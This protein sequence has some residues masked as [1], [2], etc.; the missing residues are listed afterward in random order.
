MSTRPPGRGVTTAERLSSL[1]SVLA[2]QGFARIVEAHSGLSAIIGETAQAIVNGQAVGYDAIWASGFTHSASKG[3]PDASIVGSESLLHTIDE[4][5]SVTSKPLMVDGDTGGDAVQLAYLVR[6]LER[7][8][9]SAVVI[10]D[11]VFPK[12]NS[13]DPLAMQTM[14]SPE[15][16]AQKIHAGTIATM[17]SDFMIIARI[18]SLIAGTGLQDAIQRAELYVRA[19]ADGIMIHSNQQKPDRL[20]SFVAAYDSLCQRLGRRPPLVCAPTTYNQCSEKELV[21]RGFNVI[22]HANHLLRAAHRAMKQAA[23]RILLTG[24]SAGMDDICSPVAQV[25][26]DVGFDLITREERERSTRT[27]VP[28]LIPAAGMDSIFPHVPKSL[29]SLSDRPILEHQLASIGKAG[30]QHVVVVRGHEGHQFDRYYADAPH[31]T[32]C[33]NPLYGQR[34]ILHSLMQAREFM[35]SGFIMVY[36]DLLFDHTIPERLLQG[37]RDILLACDNSY[38]YHKHA[39]D[40][41][42]DLV[43]SC[44]SSGGQ[45]RELQPCRELEVTHIG[46]NLDMAHADHEFIGIAYFSSQG[47]KTLAQVYDDCAR[48]A[49]GPFHEAIS[50]EQAAITDMLQELVDRGFPV[51]GL[52]VFK[53]WM[54]IHSLEDVR[55]AESELAAFLPRG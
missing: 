19:G 28:V 22:I 47:A 42:L 14:E 51:M 25:L 49:S 21:R 32:L 41:R 12:R 55:T 9:V 50:F 36:S 44:T 34:H 39:I 37:G 10:E 46:K 45:H 13:L 16:F 5:L 29:I 24:H 20:F 31:V 27:Q 54:E 15:T 35:A 23:H 43:A 1:R 6:Q 11:K 8:G 18:E 2:R 3:L 52:E 7:R 40:K 38:T 53:G 48:H 30:L 26:A 33:D 4:I 17:S